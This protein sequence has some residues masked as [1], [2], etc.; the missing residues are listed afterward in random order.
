MSSSPIEK[1]LKYSEFGQRIKIID[2]PKVDFFRRLIASIP[3]RN[4]G[5][6]ELTAVFPNFGLVQFR[7]FVDLSEPFYPHVRQQSIFL[8]SHS[9]PQKDHDA[10]THLFGRFHSPIKIETDPNQITYTVAPEILDHGEQIFF[11]IVNLLNRKPEDSPFQLICDA[12]QICEA[13]NLLN[14]N[15]NAILNR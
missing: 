9:L 13:Y 11:Q 6:H 10:L 12:A 7:E 1:N 2:F 15:I 3:E 5:G 8:R 14:L 4:I